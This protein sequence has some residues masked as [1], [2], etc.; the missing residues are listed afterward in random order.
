MIQHMRRGLPGWR[1]VVIVDRGLVAVRCRNGQVAGFKV[2]ADALRAAITHR[3]WDGRL[4]DPNNQRLLLY[5]LGGFKD[6]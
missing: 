4:K 1:L 5:F 2:E 3:L 6:Y